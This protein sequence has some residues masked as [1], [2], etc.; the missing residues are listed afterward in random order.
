M[1]KFQ[2]YNTYYSVKLYA[3]YFVPERSETLNFYR[4]SMPIRLVRK[5]GFDWVAGKAGGVHIRSEAEKVEDIFVFSNS[6]RPVPAL[7]DNESRY[8][9]EWKIIDEDLSFDEFWQ[10]LEIDNSSDVFS[11]WY[12]DQRPIFRT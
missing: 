6:N 9:D 2:W 10:K 8:G 7:G 1:S 12:H 3:D 4:R 11:S 5:E